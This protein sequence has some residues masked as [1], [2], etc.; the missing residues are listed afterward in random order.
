M[1]EGISLK[2]LYNYLKDFYGV[3]KARHRTRQKPEP[4]VVIGE[5]TAQC[6]EW[7]IQEGDPVI[8]YLDED[9]KLWVR[10]EVEFNS[11]R[12]YDVAS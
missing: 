3:R 2:H 8:V 1:A 7:N 5:G 9:G 12:F 6:S 10:H 11:G 4:Y